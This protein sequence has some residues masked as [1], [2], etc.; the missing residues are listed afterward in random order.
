MIQRIEKVHQPL[1]GEAFEAVIP[2]RGDVGLFGAEL[3][4]GFLLREVLQNSVDGHREPYLGLFLIRVPDA[5]IRENAMLA[6]KRS[7]RSPIRLIALRIFSFSEQ[8]R[9]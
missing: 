9:D 8:T 1:R 3:L 5:E 4:R 6:G 7:I 2:E